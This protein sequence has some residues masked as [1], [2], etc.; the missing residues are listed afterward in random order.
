M[1]WERVILGGQR[2]K[3]RPGSRRKE[4]SK[5]RA[6]SLFTIQAVARSVPAGANANDEMLD[7]IMRADVTDNLCAVAIHYDILGS[8]E[9]VAFVDPAAMIWCSMTTR[10]CASLSLLM[11]YCNPSPVDGNSRVTV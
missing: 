2:R 3:S 4:I 7:R 6:N 1:Q 9:A 11:R 8:V 5:A 10:S